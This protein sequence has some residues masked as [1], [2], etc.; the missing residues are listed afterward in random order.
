V[1]ISTSLPRDFGAFVGNIT[2]A[3]LHTVRS[4]SNYWKSVSEKSSLE[5]SVKAYRSLFSIFRP[6]SATFLHGNCTEKRSNSL[7]RKCCDAIVTRKTIFR[8]VSVQFPFPRRFYFP[9][10]ATARSYFRHKKSVTSFNKMIKV[11]LTFY[12]LATFFYFPFSFRAVSVQNVAENAL[13]TAWKTARKLRFAL[14]ATRD[15][16]TL[17]LSSSR[18]MPVCDTFR[19]NFTETARK[20]SGK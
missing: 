11:Y 12:E 20:S 2:L 15:V 17:L 4:Q 7:R 5:R 3:P 6:V 18:S 10:T 14:S 19:G 1:T 8:E 13:K 16:L 9:C